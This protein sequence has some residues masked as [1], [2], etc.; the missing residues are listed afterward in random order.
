MVR[1]K[2]V[3]VVHKLGYSKKEKKTVDLVRE[4]LHKNNILFRTISPVEVH[5]GMVKDRDLIIIVGGDGTFL[6]TAHHV[7]NKTPFLCIIAD[8]KMTEGFFSNTTKKNYANKL[9]DILKGKGKKKTLVRLTAKIG[10]KTIE[11][12][13][14]EYYIGKKRPY[15]VS[16][17]TI[18]TK[19]KKE[20]QKSSG[21]LVSTPAG[22]TA[23]TRG[24]GGKV[25]PIENKQFQFGGREPYKGKLTKMTIQKG[26]L[27]AM[28]T[29][30]II[31]QSEGMIVVADALGRE[32]RVEKGATIEIKMSKMPLHLFW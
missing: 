17:Y 20:H 28:D 22:S 24:A 31:P 21:V 14:N 8:E 11:P 19:K 26:I 32:H 5:P 27:K 10:R 15:D 29:I 25:L 4:Y 12:C 9:D 7:R 30:S 1:I 3:L 23:W 18:N 13:L 2:N 16:N 6:K